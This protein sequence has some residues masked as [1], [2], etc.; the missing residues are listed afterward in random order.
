MPIGWTATSLHLSDAIRPTGTYLNPF[1][2][3][4]DLLVV[5]PHGGLESLGLVIRNQVHQRYLVH[6]THTYSLTHTH[7]H[8]RARARIKQYTNSL[9]YIF[10][11]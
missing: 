7:T 4:D 5:I 11:V 6:S 9:L 2:C 3:F 10:T 1:L 8:T